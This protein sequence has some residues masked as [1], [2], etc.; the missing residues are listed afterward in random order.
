MLYLDY[1]NHLLA[2]QLSYLRQS[3]S[4]SRLF[5]RVCK[6]ILNR[7]KVGEMILKNDNN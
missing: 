7:G 6:I 4:S 2:P 5:L 3:Y 1:V